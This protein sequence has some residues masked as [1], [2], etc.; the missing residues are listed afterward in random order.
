MVC[1]LH[2]VLLQ[3]AIDNGDWTS[4]ALLWG[5][6]DPL[7]TE[8]FGGDHAE[9]EAVHR[10]RKALTELKNKHRQPNGGGDGD[11]EEEKPSGS[12]GHA[13]YKAKKGPAADGGGK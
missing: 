4:A 6:P 13:K 2:K 7:G 9:M 3:L 8:D 1:Q 11:E 5:S 12:R 10:Y